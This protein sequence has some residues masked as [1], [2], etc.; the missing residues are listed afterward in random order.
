MGSTR[1]RSA[2]ETLVVRG[3]GVWDGTEDR[4]LSML[5]YGSLFRSG[6][7][8]CA[9]STMLVGDRRSLRRLLVAAPAKTAQLPNA[10]NRSLARR[11]LLRTRDVTLCPVFM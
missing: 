2:K 4:L 10:A 6:L 5:T 3:T 8:R 1:P 7:P 9:P 11:G